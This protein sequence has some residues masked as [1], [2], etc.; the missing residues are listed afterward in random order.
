M[1]PLMMAA[2]QLMLKFRV[3]IGICCVHSTAVL[4][5]HLVLGCMGRWQD[6]IK[7]I[8]SCNLGPGLLL[9][10]YRRLLISLKAVVALADVT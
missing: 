1:K 10:M 2:R 8:I 4:R 5:V 6:W 7:Q 3:Q 9:Y